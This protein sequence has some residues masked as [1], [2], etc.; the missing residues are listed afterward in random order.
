MTELKQAH[1]I[2][3]VAAQQ[4]PALKLTGMVLAITGLDVLVAC[5]VQ[6]DLNRAAAAGRQY[7]L[8]KDPAAASGM[9]A[10]TVVGTAAAAG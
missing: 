5:R 4:G 10:A 8:P 2:H 1:C 3:K 9:A 7:R 6:A